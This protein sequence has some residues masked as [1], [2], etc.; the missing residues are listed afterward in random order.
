M[1]KIKVKLSLSD[2]DEVV[3]I[4]E[5]FLSMKLAYKRGERNVRIKLDNVSDKAIKDLTNLIDNF[6]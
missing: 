2:R 6:Y 1:P 3:Y 5:K 4:L